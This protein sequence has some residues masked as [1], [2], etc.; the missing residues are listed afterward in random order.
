LQPSTTDEIFCVLVNGLDRLLLSFTLGQGLRE[1]IESVSQH[2][3]KTTTTLAPATYMGSQ[4]LVL[5]LGLMI[6]CMYTGRDGD[7]AGALTVQRGG[8]AS[9]QLDN[10]SASTTSQ[11]SAIF[12]RASVA[13][14][15]ESR[16]IGMV[17]P[18]LL[19]DLLELRQ[20]MNVIM[21]KFT[22]SFVDNTHCELIATV[23]HNYFEILHVHGQQNVAREWVVLSSS[24]F[25]QLSERKKAVTSLACLFVSVSQE[26]AIRSLFSSV[27]NYTQN[28]MPINYCLFWLPAMHFFLKENLSDDVKAMF[29]QVFGSVAETPFKELA[30]MCVSL[31]MPNHSEVAENEDVARQTS[32]SSYYES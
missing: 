15:G 10:M 31:T 24:N 29:L 16:V 32:T 3:T 11:I 12:H 13:G 1:R 9:D 19:S 17:V 5:A 14:G 20:I 8:M 22:R 23:V 18:I 7:R 26:P 28:E 25:L 6:T 4:R 2:M 27:I 21:E 30:T